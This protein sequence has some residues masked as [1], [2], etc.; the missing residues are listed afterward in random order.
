MLTHLTLSRRTYTI[1]DQLCNVECIY[2]NDFLIHYR[3]TCRTGH[4]IAYCS[5]TARLLLLHMLHNY[6]T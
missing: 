2:R 1:F 5:R 4:R 3:L 6:Y